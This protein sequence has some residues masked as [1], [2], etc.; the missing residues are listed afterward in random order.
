MNRTTFSLLFLL[1]FYGFGDSV[2]TWFL[3]E[4]PV[5][6]EANPIVVSMV[7]GFGFSL[8]IAAKFAV[9]A[10]AIVLIHLVDCLELE[11]ADAV[12]VT[13]SAVIGTMGAYATLH[14]LLLLF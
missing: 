2:T 12:P 1:L 9:V 14:N 3:F 11:Y 5:L 4:D 13:Y 10:S 8:F 7:D 6:M